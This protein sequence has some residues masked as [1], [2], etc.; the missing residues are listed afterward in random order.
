MR[1][2]SSS[3]ESF[4][5]P[6]REACVAAGLWSTSSAGHADRHIPW[7]SWVVGRT[8][9]RRRW[10]NPSEELPD[11]RVRRSEHNVASHHSTT[12]EACDKNTQAVESIEVTSTRSSGMLGVP[13]SAR[14]TSSSR[15]R[16]PVENTRSPLIFTTAP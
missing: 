15:S 3:Y 7:A 9:Y 14:L 10:P 2:R 13:R 4:S 11:G 1:H 6:G 16:G 8:R 5:L 12:L